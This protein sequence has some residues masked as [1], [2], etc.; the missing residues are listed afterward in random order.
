MIQILLKGGL[1]NQMF[2]YAYALKVSQA[3]GNEKMCINGSFLK[4]SPDKRKIA[5]GNLVLADDTEILPD[6]PHTLAIIRTF[7]LIFKYFREFG[8]SAFIG[9]IYV[10]SQMMATNKKWSFLQSFGFVSL[11]EKLHRRLITDSRPQADGGAD[12]TRL[13]QSGLYYVRDYY[14]SPPIVPSTATN[15]YVWGLFQHIST[16]EGIEDELRK[17]FTVKTEASEDNKKVL[18]EIKSCNSVCLHIRR[19]DY[20]S[21]AFV[22]TLCVCDERYYVEAVRQASE[23]LDNPVFFCFSNDHE[24]LEWIK[25]N[26]HF[27][28]VDIRYVDLE[29]PDYEEH[30]LMTACKH[31]IIS[32]STFSWW[33]AV[34]SDVHPQKQV[35]TPK[36]WIKGRNVTLY[37]DSWITI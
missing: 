9:R 32:N 5:L 10:F 29:N 14:Q 35:W 24:S 20:L 34:L 17:R 8:I 18:E 1:G 30:R 3:H 22:N 23:Q 33:A 19:G 13:F 26:Y 31:F 6:L 4:Y 21:Q 15:K 28:A 36:T 37:K 16:V 25:Q 27:P 7:S 12:Y 11:I 2:E